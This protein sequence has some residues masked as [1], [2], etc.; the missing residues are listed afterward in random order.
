MKGTSAMR[1]QYAGAVQASP[2]LHSLLAS[3][4][5]ERSLNNLEKLGLGPLAR[6]R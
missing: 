5:F 6:R 2:A 4:P 3:A 1:A